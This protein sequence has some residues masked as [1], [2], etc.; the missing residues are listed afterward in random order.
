MMRTLFLLSIPLALSAAAAE[1]PAE[2]INK[3]TCT[4]GA[5]ERELE[6]VAKG[7][8]HV[9]SYTKSGATKEVGACSMNKQ[10]C[11]AVFDQI[12]SKLEKSGF[13]CSL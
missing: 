1:T 10:K 7:D 3:A 9:V 12:R 8:G 6:I 13:A 4:R 2:M 11:Q 5:D